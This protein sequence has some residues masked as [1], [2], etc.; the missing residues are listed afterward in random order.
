MQFISGVK[1][2]HAAKPPTLR[3]L[4]RELDIDP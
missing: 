1:V 4:L 2:V 3:L